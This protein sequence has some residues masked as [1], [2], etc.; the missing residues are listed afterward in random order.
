LLINE[1]N[2]CN[3]NIENGANERKQAL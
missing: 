3:I 1:Q 2:D